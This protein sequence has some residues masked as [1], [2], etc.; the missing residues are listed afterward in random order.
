MGVDVEKNNTV[1]CFSFFD[2]GDVSLAL[3]EEKTIQYIKQRTNMNN[4]ETILAV[5]R[6]AIE[7]KLFRTPVGYSYLHELQIKILQSGIDP[8]LVPD[9]PLY[10]VYGNIN[11]DAD[12]P[13][14][15]ITVNTV[16]K[17]DE[18]RQKNKRL[19][20]VNVILII[21]IIAMFI[22]SLNSSNPNILNYRNVIE[23]EYSAWEQDL[24]DRENAIKEKEREMGIQNE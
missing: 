1:N 12:K 7:K 13:K 2:D 11:V 18:L 24:T 9:I 19:V 17:R 21:I 16:K 3:N 4:A 5:Y 8:E 15:T 10:Q 20:W 6:G 23:N 22:I 14:R